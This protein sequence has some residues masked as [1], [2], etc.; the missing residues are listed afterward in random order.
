MTG[1]EHYKNKASLSARQNKVQKRADDARQQWLA[2][3]V[4]DIDDQALLEIQA[5]IR[6]TQVGQAK[7]SGVLDLAGHAAGEWTSFTMKM[8]LH[9]QMCAGALPGL[10][11]IMQRALIE[12]DEALDDCTH[13]ITGRGQ[14][15]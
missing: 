5:V 12:V 11:N 13:K 14:V 4:A 15:T 8:N 2:T 1:V 7:L 6:N 9:T 10:G 3:A